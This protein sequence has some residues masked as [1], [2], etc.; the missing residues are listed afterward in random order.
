MAASEKDVRE[1]MHLAGFP[2]EVRDDA[3][4]IVLLGL[5]NYRS[6]A[7]R[8]F[9]SHTGKLIKKPTSV[10]V[11]PKGRHDQTQARTVLISALCRAWIMGI[12]NPTL[13]HKNDPDSDFFRFAQVIMAKEG[14]GHIHE[15]L[16]RY[17]SVRKNTV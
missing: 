12:G 4:A 9:Y 16:E 6:G 1:A 15:H 13:N 2:A 17:W 3:L 7:V 11:A 8:R 10:H 14:I 5:S